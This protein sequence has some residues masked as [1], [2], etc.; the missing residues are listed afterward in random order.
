M[1][2]WVRLTS[3]DQLREVTKESLDKPVLIYKHSTRC[4]VSNIALKRLEKDSFAL[5]NMV[6]PY[7]LDLILYR[8][9]S[10]DVADY[11][12]IRHESPQ[13]LIIQNGSCIYHSSHIAISAE[14]INSILQNQ[15]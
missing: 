12:Q 15:N 1:L 5:S 2:Q 11:Y 4:G 7:F 8:Q 14:E 10:N 13:V 3:E 6:K 9:I